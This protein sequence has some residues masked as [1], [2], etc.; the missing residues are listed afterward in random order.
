MSVIW[1]LIIVAGLDSGAGRAIDVSLT[2]TSQAECR[3][4][5]QAI[6]DETDL[7]VGS[8]HWRSARAACV[9]RTI[10]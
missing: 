3:A 5:A 8:F 4:A 1:V 10:N 7:K 6:A 2:F 9:K